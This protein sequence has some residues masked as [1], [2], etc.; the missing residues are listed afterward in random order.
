MSWITTDQFKLDFATAK[1]A[2][3]PQVQMA[4]DAAEDELTE[5]VGGDATAD[6]KSV[7]PTESDRALRLIRGHKFLAVATFLLNVR[8]VKKQQDAS[9]PALNSGHLITN[10]FWTP[11]EISEMAAQWRSMAYKA[12][13]PYLII[14]VQGDEYAEAIQYDHP[15]LSAS[16]ACP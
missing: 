11:K 3:T 9:S 8:N 6:A 10:E 15:E 7:T 4:L 1:G 2:T 14:D 5:L 13:A 16:C 12:I